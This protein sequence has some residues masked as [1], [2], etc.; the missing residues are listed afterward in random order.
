[1]GD[2]GTGNGMVLDLSLD[3]GTAGGEKDSANLVTGRSGRRPSA[4]GWAD[5]AGTGADKVEKMRIDANWR[6]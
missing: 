2:N 6:R 4:A 3:S 5:D 1:M